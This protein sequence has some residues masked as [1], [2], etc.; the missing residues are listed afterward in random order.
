MMA[1]AF[2]D[3]GS[4]GHGDFPHRPSSESEQSRP[5]S[6]PPRHASRLSPSAL[7]ALRGGSEVARGGAGVVVL[8]T[9]DQL[10]WVFAALFGLGLCTVVVSFGLY[11]TFP[12]PDSVLESTGCKAQTVPTVSC[13]WVSWPAFGVACPGIT[14]CAALLWWICSLEHNALARAAQR[15]FH[16]GSG[17]VPP[18]APIPTDVTGGA[19]WWN[20]RCCTQ[21]CAT[22]CCACQSDLDAKGETT[23]RRLLFVARV[24]AVPWCL[25][26]AVLTCCSMRIEWRVHGI[27]ATLFFTVGLAY[28][29]LLTVAQALVRHATTMDRL[30]Q[31][32]SGSAHNLPTFPVDWRFRGKVAALA[33]LLVFFGVWELMWQ[34]VFQDERDHV[35]K[36]SAVEEYA[37]ILA[38][39]AGVAT[40]AEDIRL[41]LSLD[42][43]DKDR[44]ERNGLLNASLL[45]SADDK[46]TTWDG[47]SAD[48][49]SRML[50]DSQSNTLQTCSLTSTH[51]LQSDYTPPGRAVAAVSRV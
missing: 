3:R 21:C 27:S 1:S 12:A 24:L 48:G 44:L 28:L 40:F 46:S 16:Y 35:S 47:Q 4:E 33:G 42:A 17:A 19:D 15:R 23:V 18:L 49:R 45:E 37:V 22:C 9:V 32:A 11:W 5:Q 6:P 7:R 41:E 51:W 10:F 2:S 8:L 31:L 36:F 34:R 14:V 38:L 20:A 26:L 13:T 43:A 50:G 39:L 30:R 29:V 25:S